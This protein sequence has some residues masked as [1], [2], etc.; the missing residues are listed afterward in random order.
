MI[1]PRPGNK[2]IFHWI[3]IMTISG[4]LLFYTQNRPVTYLIISF[5]V[6][7]LIFNRITYLRLNT[8]S[9]KITKTNFLFI[10][11][12]KFLINLNDIKG[13]SVLDYRAIDINSS[14]KNVEFEAVVIIEALTGTL[15]YKPNY[16]LVIDL[17]QN[18]RVEFELNSDKESDLK[19]II[20]LQK[21][22]SKRDVY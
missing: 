12:Y 6:M 11:T 20:L 21:E 14:K 22:L 18:K 8:H 5:I 3:F 7:P 17:K 19:M 13:L 1:K 9:L 16:I 4:L 2:I 10:P 15:F